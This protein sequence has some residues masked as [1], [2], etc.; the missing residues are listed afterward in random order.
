MVPSCLNQMVPSSLKPDGSCLVEPDSSFL[1]ESDGSFLRKTKWFLLA[2]TVPDGSFLCRILYQ[3]PVSCQQLLHISMVAMLLIYA[4]FAENRNHFENSLHQIL[5]YYLLMLRG[6]RNLA[7]AT[8]THILT[9]TNITLF[10]LPLSSYSSSSSFLLIFYHLYSCPFFPSPLFL[11]PSFIHLLCFP[12]SP[13][14]PHFPSAPSLLSL[15]PSSPRLIPLLSLII[16]SLL[17]LLPFVILFLL[18]SLS[19]SCFSSYSSS[20]RVESLVDPEPEPTENG[21]GSVTLVVL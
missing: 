4:L 7:P 20:S 1:P 8:G 21:P 15:F 5:P 14:L 12:S 9:H 17:I 19:Y 10:F 6:W 2:S 16:F 13:R 3:T 18:F 11:S